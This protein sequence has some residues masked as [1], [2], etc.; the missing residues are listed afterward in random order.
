MQALTH[1][2][3]QASRRITGV[4]TNIDGTLTP[5]SAITLDALAVLHELKAAGLPVIAVTGRSVDWSEP[6]AQGW[7]VNAIGA[8]HG[9]VALLSAQKGG[10]R[11][12]AGREPLLKACQYDTHVRLANR[13]CIQQVARRVMKEIPGTAM[14]QDSVGRETN[15]AID[16]SEFANLNADGIAQVVKIMRS[17]GMTVRWLR[18]S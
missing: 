2:P 14:A 16:P 10:S 9:A 8:E 6:F 11:I 1:W 12:S 3:L 4:L 5:Q 15:M 17:G 7:P 13:A 18:S